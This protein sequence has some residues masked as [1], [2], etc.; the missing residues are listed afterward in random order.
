MMAEFVVKAV[1]FV[2]PV[3]SSQEEDQARRIET[4]IRQVGSDDVAEREKATEELRKIG[5]PAVSALQKAAESKDPEVAV[6]ARALV[7][8]LAVLKRD[9]KGRVIV[10]LERDGWEVHQRWD[11]FG[12][13]I[14]KRWEHPNDRKN[15]WVRQ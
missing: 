13:L 1:F 9:E 5:K 10:Q 8:E 2:F 12:N 6:R 3:A 15:H 4:L 11:E 7:A 14:E